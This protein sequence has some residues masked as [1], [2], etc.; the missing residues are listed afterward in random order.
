MATDTAPVVLVEGQLASV[1]D[2]FSVNGMVIRSAGCRVLHNVWHNV[3][4]R[5]AGVRCLQVVPLNFERHG[6]AAI[7]SRRE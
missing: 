7:T 5:N 3:E 4:N 1:H 2:G 6:S